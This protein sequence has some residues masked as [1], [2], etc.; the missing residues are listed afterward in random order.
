M[1]RKPVLLSPSKEWRDPIFAAPSPSRKDTGPLTTPRHREPPLSPFRSPLMGSAN[2]AIPAGS[3]L[4]SRSRRA[5]ASPVRDVRQADRGDHGGGG[6]NSKRLAQLCILRTAQAQ[7]NSAHLPRPPS[8]AQ[9]SPMF[10]AESPSS[11]LCQAGSALSSSAQARASFESV[12]AP[13]SAPSGPRS[14]REG[15]ADMFD[16]FLLPAPAFPLRDQPSSPPPL[17][18]AQP[19]QV[20]SAEDTG[21]TSADR[22]DRCEIL[23]PPRHADDDATAAAMA[24]EI[25]EKNVT[26][27]RDE[28]SGENLGGQEGNGVGR[29]RMAG[30]NSGQMGVMRAEKAALAEPLGTRAGS[31]CAD[32]ENVGRID[33]RGNLGGKRGDNPGACSRDAQNA[34]VRS[35]LMELAANKKLPHGPRKGDPMYECKRCPF[36][37]PAR[38][39]LSHSAAL[40]PPVHLPSRLHIPPALTGL[41]CGGNGGVGM[42]RLGLVAP[43]LA[44]MPAACAST[45]SRPASNARFDTAA[46]SVPSRQRPAMLS[47]SRSAQRV[48]RVSGSSVGTAL[49]LTRSTIK[50][51]IP[52]AFYSSDQYGERKGQYRPQSQGYKAGNQQRSYEKSSYGGQEYPQSSQYKRSDQQSSNQ[53]SQYDQQP[54]QSRSSPGSYQRR[55]EQQQPPQQPPPPP[56]AQQ[57]QYG[58]EEASD[59][60][61]TIEWQSELSNSVQ[62]IGN[63]AAEPALR[64]FD[65]G[66]SV[67][68]VKLAV[69]WKKANGEKRTDWYAIEMWNDMANLAQNLKKGAQV[70]VKGRLHME[71]YTDRNGV[72]KLDP[73]VDV[74]QICLVASKFGAS[75]SNQSSSRGRETSPGGYNKG[76]Y[77]QGGYNQGAYA[78]Q[79]TTYSEQNSY[80]SSQGY[81]NQNYGNQAGSGGQGGAMDAPVV[82]TDEKGLPR[83]PRFDGKLNAGQVEA[84][85]REFFQD[86]VQFFDY[87]EMKQHNEVPS[88]YPDFKKLA[89]GQPLWVESRGTPPWVHDSLQRYDDAFA[90]ALAG[91]PL[92][93]QEE[94]AAG[95]GGGEQFQEEFGGG[96]MDARGF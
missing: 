23:E 67:A 55:G 69:G 81:D 57:Q 56:A 35:T 80:S 13:C 20:P 75:S 33:S 61:E 43:A 48:L 94:G 84:L 32:R 19:A 79:E 92:E 71:E 50:R 34:S 21:A 91:M 42:G 25:A 85:W 52:A 27:A 60:I 64:F 41:T 45:L 95:A 96:A 14:A 16:P 47:L 11:L 86:P 46:P 26:M 15:A 66:N 58:Q 5:L 87:R 82:V 72:L 89:T 44:T 90:L 59:E 3:P 24:A 31:E 29:I 17:P 30:E 39:P 51:I 28:R 68:R 62:L 77:N 37:S 54:Y 93:G 8:S 49:I 53:F 1:H 78:P 22:G 36:A 40:T 18:V 74:K 63:I 73:K 4:G 65:N 83:I 10:S 6:G 88:K 70:Y 38:S 12:Q 2:P 9:P 7:L 76:S